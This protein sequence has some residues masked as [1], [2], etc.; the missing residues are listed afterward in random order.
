MIDPK[1]ITSFD[2]SDTNLEEFF[3]FSFAVAGKNADITA[4]K[5]NKLCNMLE[6]LIAP[7]PP[8]QTLILLK[9]KDHVYTIDK[10][11]RA[12]KL[13]KYKSWHRMLHYFMWNTDVQNFLRHAQLHHFLEIHGIGPKTSRFF[14][15]HS[16]PN[17]R[18]AV[19]DTHILRWLSQSHRKVPKSTPRGQNYF[20]WERI[21]IDRMESIKGPN[22]TLADVDLHLWKTYSGRGG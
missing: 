15:I 19:L 18:Y 3:L 22:E 10:I 17:Q 11:L 16:R 6:T 4:E 1:N 9:S 13:G 7:I 20:D 21:A 14:L 2:R 12:C 5:I 8:L